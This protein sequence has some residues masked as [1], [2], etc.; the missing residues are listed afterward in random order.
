PV[1]LELGGKSPNIVLPDARLDDAVPAILR[2]A[3]PNS[4]QTCSAGS[5]VLVHKSI[6][7]EFVS[8][9]AG[10]L[11]NLT[12]GRGL[13]DPDIG[14]LI[15]EA[16]QEKVANYIEIGKRDGAEFVDGGNVVGGTE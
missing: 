1:L 10:S 15:S 3:F 4:G 16:Q 9:I 11:S 2:A 12:V 7:D 5:R 13:D 8:R 14:P 6:Q